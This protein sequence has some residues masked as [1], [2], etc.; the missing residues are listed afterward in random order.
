MQLFC[1]NFLAGVSWWPSLVGGLASAAVVAARRLG[2]LHPEAAGFWDRNGLALAATGTFMMEGAAELVRQ[3]AVMPLRVMHRLIM[4]HSLDVDRQSLRLCGLLLR[5]GALLSGSL[6][7]AGAVAASVI[8]T[9][10]YFCIVE[11]PAIHSSSACQQYIVDG[12]DTCSEV[13]QLIFCRLYR[14]HR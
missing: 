9:W 6:A 13:A 2:L 11:L 12:L 7:D 14:L 1:H 8:V 10:F 3:A 4:C 5:T